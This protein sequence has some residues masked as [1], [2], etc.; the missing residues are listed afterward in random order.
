MF[1][2]DARVTATPVEFT[3]ECG[4]VA[5][6][7]GKVTGAGRYAPGKKV[8]LKATANKG[9]VFGGWYEIGKR[10]EGSGNGDDDG[11]L[12]QQASFSFEMGEKDIDLYA[13][14]VTVEADKGSIAA[15]FNG[16]AMPSSTDGSPAVTTNVWCGVYLEWPIAADALSQTTV[17]VA[18][19]PAGLKFADKPV[20]SKVGTGKSAVTVG[21]HE[22]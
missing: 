17:K 7:G 6:V 3:N 16:A 9:F 21:N 20:T 15:T 22:V 5:S 8:T 19:L 14:F 4:V 18:G 11:L 1:E 2:G 10:E 13:R 12:S